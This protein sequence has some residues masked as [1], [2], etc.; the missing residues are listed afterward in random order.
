VDL[1]E[2]ELE[3]L[4]PQGRWSRRGF[5]TTSLITGFALSVPADR[6]ADRHHHR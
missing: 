6:G 5:V 2:P 4:V 3:G 1:V